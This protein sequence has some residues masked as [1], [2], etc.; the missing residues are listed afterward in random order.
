MLA[1][2]ACT[3]G[4]GA[5]SGRP[6]PMATR[7]LFHRAFAF[8][9]NYIS[10]PHIQLQENISSLPPMSRWKAQRCERETLLY[11]TRHFL[12]IHV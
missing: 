7:S 11:Y 6:Y 2:V 4:D 12:K 3:A 9:S 5:G 1:N 10:T 8:A